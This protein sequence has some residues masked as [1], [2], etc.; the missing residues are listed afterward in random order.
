MATTTRIPIEQYLA[1][2]CEPDAEYVNGEVEERNV[3]QYDHSVVQRA[4]LLWFH[5]HD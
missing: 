2:S 3:G 1:T 5:L 4:I